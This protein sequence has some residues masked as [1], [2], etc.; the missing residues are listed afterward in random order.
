MLRVHVNILRSM[1]NCNTCNNLCNLVEPNG[2]ATDV[3]FEAFSKFCFTHR[4]GAKLGVKH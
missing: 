1:A 3:L 4:V 2:S